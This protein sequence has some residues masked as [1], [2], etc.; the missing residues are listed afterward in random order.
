MLD[1][2]DGLQ[3]PH[4]MTASRPA[5]LVF[6]SIGADLVTTVDEFPKPGETVVG[7]SFAQYSGG[8]G[9]NQALAAARAGGQVHMFGAVGTDDFAAPATALLRAG[10]VDMAG[11]EERPGS[12]G[13]A[14]IFVSAKGQNCIA[15]FAGANGVASSAGVPDAALTPQA[16]VVMQHECPHDANMA[17]ARRARAAGSTVLLN[18]APARPLSLEDLKTIDILIVNESEAE[19]LALQHGWPSSPT[20]F[21]YACHQAT[22]QSVVVTLGEAGVIAVVDGQMHRVDAPRVDVVDTTGAGDA[23]VGAFAAKLAEGVSLPDA[24]RYGV[25]SGSLACTSPGAQ[26]GLPF[27]AAIEELAARLS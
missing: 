16:V 12:T 11:V 27:K 6:G 24:L 26:V 15:V 17:L 8:K 7:T 3:G 13:I 22:G 4:P 20:E 9:S 21:A 2:S 14:T 23:F 18:A 1:N 19:A 10:G 25:A 5:I